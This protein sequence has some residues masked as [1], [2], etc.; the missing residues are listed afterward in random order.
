MKLESIIKEA[1]FIGSKT[2]GYINHSNKEIIKIKGFNSKF[3]NYKD[4]KEQLLKNSFK[5]Y[6]IS[7][8]RN[9]NL[10]NIAYKDITKK[11]TNTIS[12]KRIPIYNNHNILINTKPIHINSIPSRKMSTKINSESFN[13]IYLYYFLISIILIQICII[14]YLLYLKEP[15]II[16]TKSNLINHNISEQFNINKYF[17][18]NTNYI[19]NKTDLYTNYIDYNYLLDSFRSINYIEKLNIVDYNI[20]DSYQMN[21]NSFISDISDISSINQLDFNDLNRLIKPVSNESLSNPLEQ[22]RAMRQQTINNSVEHLRQVSTLTHYPSNESFHEDLR[23]SVN[24][25]SK[26]YTE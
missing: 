17:Q 5:I 18:Y 24:E 13:Q 11:L 3:I 21:R 25:I 22:E 15:I 8:F 6:P 7:I 14:L 2:Y 10:Y 26:I 20:K 12:N 23:R 1:T 16:N 19:N 4:I 9:T